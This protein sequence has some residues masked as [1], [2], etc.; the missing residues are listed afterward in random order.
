MYSLWYLICYIDFFFV[1][2]LVGSAVVFAIKCSVNTLFNVL[3]ALPLALSNSSHQRFAESTNVGRFVCALTVC[4]FICVT[5]STPSFSRL[6]SSYIESQS[7]QCYNSYVE[8]HSLIGTHN[9]IPLY[10]PQSDWKSIITNIY[11][12]SEHTKSFSSFARA[13]CFV[14]IYRLIISIESY[15]L[16]SS[17]HLELISAVD[18]RTGLGDVKNA[19][20]SAKLSRIS[21][22]TKR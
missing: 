9:G 3:Y 14:L 19:F 12:N 6:C 1:R 16:M 7:H 8:I 22:L 5:P 13:S 21:S 18:S 4:T 2:S 10:F 11:S 20:R 17:T 15:R